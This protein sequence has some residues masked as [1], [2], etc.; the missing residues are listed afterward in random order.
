MTT[1]KR[2]G[3]LLEEGGSTQTGEYRILPAAENLAAHIFFLML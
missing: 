2:I 3:D 1:L